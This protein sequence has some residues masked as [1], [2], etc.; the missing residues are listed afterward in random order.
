MKYV[1]VGL[2]VLVLALCLT[3]LSQGC[4]PE[5]AK[6]GASSAYEAQ[7]L[8]CV[9]KFRVKKDIDNCRDAVKRNWMLDAGKDA[10]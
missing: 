3:A 5:D 7:Q 4:F 10:P 1:L 2:A 6:L 9:E 8:S